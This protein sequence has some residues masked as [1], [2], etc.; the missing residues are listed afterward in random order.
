[1]AGATRALEEIG[2]EHG[3][4]KGLCAFIRPPRVYLAG[5][6]VF[7]P[8]ERQESIVA[9]KKELCEAAG[10]L[11]VYPGDGEVSLTMGDD[12]RA[13]DIYTRNVRVMNSCDTILA[14]LTPF[15]GPS[16]DVG[17]AWEIGH[18]IGSRKPA[19]GYTNSPLK[20]EDRIVTGAEGRDLDGM[21]VERQGKT[22]NCMLT[23][24][25]LN[26]EVPTQAEEIGECPYISL[27][28]FERALQAVREYY[29]PENQRASTSPG[30][31]AEGS[32]RKRHRR[33]RDSGRK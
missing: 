11:G 25:L 28:V 6:E 22:D 12:E 19:F 1:M 5:Y 7:L 14:N 20:Y 8:A 26:L 9:R 33:T 23:E 24:C 32:K 15:R 17:T 21:A 31:T 2:K 29:T 3:D 16:A 13:R 10:L 30:P 27:S 4:K 18:F